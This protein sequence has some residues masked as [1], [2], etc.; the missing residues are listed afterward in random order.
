ME[1]FKSVQLRFTIRD[2]SGRSRSGPALK[3][4]KDSGLCK[5]CDSFKIK[6]KM[7]EYIE[8]MMEPLE[9]SLT[10]KMAKGITSKIT[11]RIVMVEDMIDV[12]EMEKHIEDAISEKLGFP[13]YGE[14]CNCSCQS[15]S[16]SENENYRYGEPETF[17]SEIM[18]SY[19]EHCEECKN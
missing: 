10:R 19:K 13:K 5:Y 1:I 16:S 2:W 4:H 15:S 18:D 14:R 7:K 9:D 17:S 8:D 11:G 3:S 6:V 12:T